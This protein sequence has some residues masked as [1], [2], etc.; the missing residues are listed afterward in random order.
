MKIVK[1]TAI[2]LF[3]ITLPIGVI[4]GEKNRMLF[5]S[6]VGRSAERLKTECV[7]FQGS[8][9]LPHLSEDFDGNLRK[10]LLRGHK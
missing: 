9:T 4:A 10:R 1:L 8:P 3:L 5:N 6:I 7:Y 2:I